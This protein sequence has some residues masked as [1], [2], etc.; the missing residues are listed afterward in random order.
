MESLD[1]KTNFQ[2]KGEYKN[3]RI[4]FIDPEEVINYIVLKQ[5][6]IEYYKKGSVEMKFIFDTRKKTKGIYQIMG[7][8]LH[9]DI[10][11]KELSINNEELL[12]TYDLLQDNERVNTNKLQVIFKKPKEGN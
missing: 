3:N 2:V 12:V 5:D 9:F 10:N 8:E 4:K 11:T 6:S 1:S 7:N